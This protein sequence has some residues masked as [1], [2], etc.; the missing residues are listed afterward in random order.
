MCSKPLA[1]ASEPA[2]QGK[3]NSVDFLCMPLDCAHATARLKRP[4]ET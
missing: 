4:T 3:A 1:A 2:F